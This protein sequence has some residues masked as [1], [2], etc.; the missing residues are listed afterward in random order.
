VLAWDLM[1]LIICHGLS[2]SRTVSDV[3]DAHGMTT[4]TLSAID[5][6]P[7]RIA[8]DPWPF[9]EARVT[10]ACEGKV[11]AGGPFADEAGMR[12]ALA[13]APRVDVRATLVPG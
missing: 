1:S 11:L 8:V 13:E 6:D 9:T 4:L 10:V 5:D 12:K 7:E 3:P 2:G